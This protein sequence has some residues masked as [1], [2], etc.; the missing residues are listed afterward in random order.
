MPGIFLTVEGVEGVGKSTHLHAIVRQL[1]AASR[2]VIQ[3]RE[4][5]GTPVGEEIRELL[6]TNRDSEI[7]DDTELLLM[8]AARA[9]HV[10]SLIQPSLQNGHWVVCDRFVDATYAYQGAGR[11]IPASRISELEQWCLHGF[12]PD[13][14]LLL[15]APVAVGMARARERGQLDRFEREEIA[16]FERVRNC[17]LERAATMPDRFV[18]IDAGQPL[19]SVSAAVETAIR[20]ILEQTA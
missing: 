12:G 16:F 18:V 2:N 13:Y 3:T 19:A 11:G 10:E 9:A 4:P 6:L 15:D 17:Y 8:F 14:T 5:G 1:R 7:N 20:N